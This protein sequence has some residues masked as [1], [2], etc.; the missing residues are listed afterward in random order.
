MNRFNYSSYCWKSPFSSLIQKELFILSLIPPVGSLTMVREENKR[1]SRSFKVK[2][3]WEQKKSWKL[4]RISAQYIRFGSIV[5]LIR[6]NRVK[7][8]VLEVNL[9]TFRVS[10]LYW[11]R[12]NY[13]K[14]LSVLSSV[15]SFVL[16]RFFLKF[17]KEK[18]VQL[19]LAQD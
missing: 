5:Q 2:E 11:L 18:F 1:N 13:W 10:F 16:I 7:D 17:Y 12:Q 15:S 3:N 19:M 8:N 4:Q 6:Y 9:I 14:D